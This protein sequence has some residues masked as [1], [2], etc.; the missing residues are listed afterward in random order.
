[1]QPQA[2]CRNVFIVECL[3][4]SHTNVKEAFDA[5]RGRLV[6]IEVFDPDNVLVGRYKVER[7]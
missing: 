7:P 5:A 1:M 6:F 3:G 4:G 2:Y